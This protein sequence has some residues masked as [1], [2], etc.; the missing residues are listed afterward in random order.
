[1]VVWI[2]TVETQNSQ[3]VCMRHTQFEQVM[4]VLEKWFSSWV[5]IG[6]LED[7]KNVFRSVFLEG[8]SGFACLMYEW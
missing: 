7:W 1:M 8:P 5:S 4:L 6:H 3:D 2:R